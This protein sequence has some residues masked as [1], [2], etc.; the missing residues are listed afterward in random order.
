M[1]IRH[2]NQPQ[3]PL[4]GLREG[5]AAPWVRPAD[6]PGLPWILDS[7]QAMVGLVA[8]N[9]TDNEAVAV[10]CVGAYTVDWGDGNSQNVATNT[11]VEH[12]YNYSTLATAVTSRGYKTAIVKIT[13]QAGQNLTTIN[14]QQRPAGW[15]VQSGP[16]SPW[17]DIQINA[18]SV[19]SLVIGGSTQRL[20]QVERLHIR[21]HACTSLV[22]LCESMESLQCI[23]LFNTSAVTNITNMLL[24]CMALRVIPLFDFGNVTNAT[25]ALRE[26]FSLPTIPAFNFVKATDITNIFYLD[27]ALYAIPDMIFGA[28][29]AAQNFCNGCVGLRYIGALDFSLVTNLTNAWYYSTSLGRS[30]IT[31]IKITH[32]V[33]NCSLSASALNEIFTNLA[34]GVTGQTITVSNNPGAATCDT[35][36]ATAKGWTV[37]T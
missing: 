3:F 32:T 22:S 21:A 27:E 20:S 4:R 31:G 37:V 6:W 8:V 13:P 29:T 34:S 33:A 10:L 16:S 5:P 12:V 9:D 30:K 24:R 17:L 2:A 23:V 1:S 15:G 11:K 35:S 28:L 19:T 7:E 18:A 25:G 36:I 14:L 26:C